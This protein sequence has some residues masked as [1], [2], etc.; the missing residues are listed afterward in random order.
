MYLEFYEAIGKK[1]KFSDTK[2]VEN[3]IVESL[4]VSPVKTDKRTQKLDLNKVINN[5]IC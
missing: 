2:Q 5:F 1:N 4:K 3:N